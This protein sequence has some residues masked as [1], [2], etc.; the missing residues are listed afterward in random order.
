MAVGAVVFDGR[1]HV[2]LI[3]RGKPPGAGTWSLPGGK[4]RFGESLSDAVIREVREETS[5]DVHPERLVDVVEIRREGFHYVV[6]D[7]LCTVRG[8]PLRAQAC[9][10]AAALSWVSLDHLAQYEVTGAVER[11][12]RAAAQSVRPLGTGSR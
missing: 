3:Q 6:H 8:D 12:V 2:L 10:D 5:L 9:D 1:G 4:V 11:I 7:Y